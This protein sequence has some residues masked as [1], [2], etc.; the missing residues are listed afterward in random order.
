VV[1]SVHT[2]ICM[3]A[4]Y[5][6]V[7]IGHS[8]Q[9]NCSDINDPNTGNPF[10]NTGR[11]DHAT[12]T[13][14]TGPYALVQ[15]N[16]I[17]HTTGY[18]GNPQI[19]REQS[20][21]KRLLLAVIAPGPGTSVYVATSANGPWTGAGEKGVYNNPTLVPRPDGSVVLFCHDCADDK[22]GWGDSA[23]GMM[24]KLPTGSANYTW[25]E[26]APPASGQ[27][28]DPTRLGQLYIHPME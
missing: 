12:S 15:E 11:I 8:T 4:V 21:Q 24:G 3:C 23:M 7:D 28:G 6:S 19:F 13:S 1:T 27:D 5:A 22:I 20:G 16:V 14:P 2:L 9:R 10:V 25:N 18:V 17:P 26:W